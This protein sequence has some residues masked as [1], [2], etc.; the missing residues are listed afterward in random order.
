MCLFPFSLPK[1]QPAL[2]IVFN[3][4]TYRRD[5]FISEFIHAPYCLYN[6]TLCC[7]L[8]ICCNLFSH[9][10]FGE[11]LS[12]FHLYTVMNNARVNRWPALWVWYFIFLS[13]Y[14]EEVCN[15]NVYSFT[16][17]YQISLHMNWSILH[18][19]QHCMKVF[20]FIGGIW[21]LWPFF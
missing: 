7:S 10:P 6:C 19:Q 12:Y 13:V 4:S 9:F 14:L 20:F 15:W 2:Y 1:R 8:W 21:C 17:Y 18:F 16:R 3:L 11:Y 5:H